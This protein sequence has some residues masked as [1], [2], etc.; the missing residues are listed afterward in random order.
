MNLDP[1]D[2]RLT[3]YLL[4]E[5]SP[6]EMAAVEKAVEQDPH[7]RETLAELKVACEFMGGTL[8]PG[9]LKLLPAQRDAIRR[10]AILADQTANLSV[11]PPP[12]K[13]IPLKLVIA[14]LAAAAALGAGI[15][16]VAQLPEKS[17]TPDVISIGNP[18]APAISEET[19]LP[20]PGP[21]DVSGSS[22]ASA[23]RPPA[24]DYPEL[25][26]RNSVKTAEA[27]SIQL[28]V[29]AGDRSLTWITESIQQEGKLPPPNAV[30]LEE[31]LN[32]FKLRPA[33]AA[34]IAKGI[35]L[36]A[37]TLPCPWKPSATLLVVSV[38]GAA[39]ADHEV[40][41]SF[42]ADP[43]AVIRYRLLGYSPV[44]GRTDDRELESTVAAKSLVTVA[45]E[46]EPIG[47]A[48]EF[49][50]IQWSVDGDA[51]AAV[52]ITLNPAAE[53]S[54]DARFAALVCTY[55]QWLAGDQAGIVD[56]EIVAAMARE[57]AADN[58]PPERYKLLELIDRSLNL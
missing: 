38:R 30:R 39:N 7:L 52:P 23:A 31:I 19:V 14:P 11:A 16:I 45:L 4:G 32:H 50:A 29:Q 40:R 3:A 1:E 25:A 41:A 37:E 22:V 24:P 44:T 48:K 56:E 2:S 42:Q 43:T 20:T 58:L 51:A 26:I 10:S 21:T 46:I 47:A 8:T 28:P 13:Q 34:G 36:S 5:L 55:A 49:G 9:N 12:K 54:D 35:T 18:P 15:F 57:V 27:A 33:G 6:E 53:P 17:A